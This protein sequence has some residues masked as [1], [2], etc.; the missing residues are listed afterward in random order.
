ML[1]GLGIANVGKKTGKQLSVISYQLSEKKKIS[2]LETLFSVTEE[3]LLEV[4]DIG[5]E[6]ARSFVE[7]MAENREVVERLYGE[8]EIQIPINPFIKGESQEKVSGM[9]AGKSFCV[10]GS[11][12]TLSRDEIHE[13]VEQ[14]GGEV[15]TSVSSR[16][17][18]LI[19]GDNAGSKRSKAEE[20]GVIIISIDEFLKMIEK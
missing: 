10:T 18:Y 16:L 1:V 20:C 12:D 4:K 14:N 3:D 7:Y 6:T 8:L 5:P 11:F 17:D 9:I 15:R 13:L 2:L 19:A